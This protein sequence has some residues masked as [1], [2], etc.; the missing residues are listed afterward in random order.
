MK[1]LV[2]S[3]GAQ[4]SVHSAGVGAGTTFTVVFP[5]MSIANAVAELHARPNDVVH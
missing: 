3:H 4:I 1:H 2:D 5:A